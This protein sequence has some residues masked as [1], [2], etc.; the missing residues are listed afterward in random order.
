MPLTS[1][2]I[3]FENAVGRLSEHAN[4]YALVQYKPGK[5]EFTDFQALLT[6][7][8]HLLARRRWHKV[9][10]DQRAIT[11]FT[12]QERAW[13]NERWGSG[14][15][16]PPQETVAALLLPHDVFA[17]L[18]TSQI[19]HDARAGSLVYHIFEDE[20]AAGTWLRQAP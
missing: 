18:S 1:H 6:H 4:G 9:L 5:R 20:V 15:T 7:L 14:A 13:V 12:D 16:E 8:G 10:T 2:T 19:I 3:Y 17:R 11:P